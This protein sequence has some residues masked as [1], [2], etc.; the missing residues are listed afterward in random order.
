VLGLAGSGD[1]Y[2][3][4]GYF[5]HGMGTKNKA[6]AGAG[7]ALP[8]E[9]MAVV[10]NPAVAVAVAGRSEIGLAVFLPKSSYEA[11][12][13]AQ[14]GQNGAFTIGPGQLDAEDQTL[15]VPYFARSWQLREDSAFAAAL[16]TRS[17]INTEYRGG[18]ATFD[19]DGPGPAPVV[20][21]P[22]TLGDGDV[23]WNLSQAL[24]DLGYAKQVTERVSLGASAVLAAQSLSIRGVGSL[25]PLTQTWASSGGSEL[26]T[27]LSGNGSDRSYGAGL[28][29][30]AHFQCTQ[31]LSLG[32]MMQ[33]KILMSD[34][35]EYSDLLPSGG[36]FD[37]PA[38]L[39]LGLSWRFL[40]HAVF[41][42]DTEYIFYSDIEALGNSGQ[43]LY[44]C[45][46]AGSGGTDLSACLG[47]S[48]GAGLGWKNV[49]VYKF[50]L[51]WKVGHNWNL[52]GGFSF[53]DQP[54]GVSEATNNLLTPY[55]NESTYTFGFSRAIGTGKELN[56]AFMYTEEESHLEPNAFDP[57]PLIYYDHSEF[58][59]ELSY[60]WRF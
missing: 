41:S 19:P 29:L 55:L 3:T 42:I 31:T 33:S 53:G 37:I 17:G 27:H 7:I 18:T 50:G 47:G 40:D 8:D 9:A 44:Q 15:L 52:R 1:L 20:T 35:S 6:M 54:V 14:N 38:D 46:A 24:L 30:G 59:L 51:D 16:Y 36:N 57:S 26:P 12:A 11:S 21:Q 39:K 43:N 56:F 23:K 10:N 2:A 48:N 32:L 34:L 13:S 45:P 5:N 49:P 28:K 25:A 60:G 58:E 22:G 4:N